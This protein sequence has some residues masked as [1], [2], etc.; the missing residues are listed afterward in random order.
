MPAFAYQALDPSGK[1]KSGILDGDS[2]RQV[3]QRLRDQ[4]LAPTKVE[5][6]TQQTAGRGISIGRWFQALVV[7][8]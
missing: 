2:A 4:G 6:T 3:R 8:Y 1:S 7:C 5:L